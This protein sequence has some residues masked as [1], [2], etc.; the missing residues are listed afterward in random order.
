VQLLSLLMYS[1][2]RANCGNCDF[3]AIES[4]SGQEGSVVDNKDKVADTSL[5]PGVEHSSC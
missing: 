2:L 3:K 4:L 5:F 1:T